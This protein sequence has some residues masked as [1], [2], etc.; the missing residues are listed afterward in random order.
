M[1][2][3]DQELFIKEVKQY[4]EASK[5]KRIANF[6]IDYTIYLGLAFIVGGIIGII[7]VAIYGEE[8]LLLIE[9]ESFSV[10]LLDYAISALV[11]LAYYTAIEY[12]SNGKSLGKLIT[13]TRAVQRSGEL[14]TFPIALKRSACRL[15]PFNPFSF[16]GD[17]SNGWH[18]SIPNTKVID[19]SQPIP[20]SRAKAEIAEGDY[21]FLKKT[22]EE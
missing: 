19:E 4:Y 1:D 8:I 22:E 3:I 5:G 2:I 14:M 10:K 15:I 13:K 20:V 11:M 16:L 18:D 12:Y 9:E 17:L 7:L 21:D 6:I